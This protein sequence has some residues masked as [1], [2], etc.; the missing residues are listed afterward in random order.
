MLTDE[1]VP[2]T[3]A[4]NA[5][6]SSD[7]SLTLL[8]KSWFTAQLYVFKWN[9]VLPVNSPCAS[10]RTLEYLVSITEQ[11]S[12]F[13]VVSMKVCLDNYLAHV[14]ISRMI[15]AAIMII[16]LL[17]QTILMNWT[18]NGKTG[19][20]ETYLW[21]IYTNPVLYEKHIYKCLYLIFIRIWL[22]NTGH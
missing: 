2:T 1:N 6:N 7:G 20:S 14:L 21:I 3:L 4:F 18:N 10:A 11:R 16:N 9:C 13:S 15:I 5:L 17:Q 19:Y 12:L 22:V 8:V